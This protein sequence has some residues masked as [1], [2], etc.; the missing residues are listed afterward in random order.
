MAE[1]VA[2]GRRVTLHYT[3]AL[4]DGTVLDRTDGELPASFHIG[5]GELVAFLEQHLIGLQPG[6]QRRFEIPAAATR[7]ALEEGALQRLPRTDFPADVEPTPGQVFGFRLAGDEEIPGQV[8]AV[9]DRE[10][11][12]DFSHPLAGRDLIFD[13]EIISVEP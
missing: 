5:S 10:V 2:A 3:L 6:D 1:K 7:S 8:V 11:T 13:V 12:V 9:T 4:A